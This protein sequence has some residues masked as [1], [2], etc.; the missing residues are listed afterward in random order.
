M[1]SHGLLIAETP[2]TPT[3]RKAPHHLLTGGSEKEIAAQV[4]QS[5]NTTHEHV[6][7]L[8]RKLGVKN[9]SALMA[10]GRLHSGMEIIKL[11]GHVLAA[12]MGERR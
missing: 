3:E 1:L 2:L 10:L 6:G 7:T 4:G 5:Y 8:Y 11:N 9:R 12:Q